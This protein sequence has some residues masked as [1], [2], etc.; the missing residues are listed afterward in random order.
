MSA[1]DARVAGVVH[2]PGCP[3]ADVRV[4]CECGENRSC[5]TCGWGSG[6]H[7][8]RCARERMSAA[9]AR[10]PKGALPGPVEALNGD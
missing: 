7:P 9:N 8:C 2:R 6:S 3:K 1:S 4:Y 5:A 10:V